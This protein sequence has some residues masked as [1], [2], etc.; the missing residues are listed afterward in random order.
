MAKRREFDVLIVKDF[1]RFARDHILVCDY[2]DQIF[3]FLGIRFLSV[4]DGYD[5]SKANGRTS[6]IDIGFRNIVNSYYSQD[7][8]RKVKS[9]MRTKATKGIA[10]SGRPPFGY[11]KNKGGYY[12]IEPIAASVVSY[13]FDLAYK[14]LTTTAIA[15][16]LNKEQIP[17]KSMIKL[18][19]IG[20]RRNQPINKRNYWTQVSIYR[21]LRD[22]QYLGKLIFGK[23]NKPSVSDKRLIAVPKEDWIV[24]ANAHD[25][26]IQQEIFDAV[27]SSF[28]KGHHGSRNAQ[29][30][31]FL[32]KIKCGICKRAM[33]RTDTKKPDYFCAT[34][35]Y[36]SET[37]CLKEKLSEDFVIQM[38]LELLKDLIQRYVEVDKIKKSRSSC[39]SPR[40]NLALYQAGLEKVSQKKMELFDLWLE[41]NIEKDEYLLTLKELKQSTIEWK[42]AIDRTTLQIQALT[43][44]DSKQLPEIDVLQKWFQSKTLT[45]EMVDLFINCIYIY[46]NNQIEIDWNFSD[47]IN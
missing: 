7:L 47:P 16:R 42:N 1:S 22:E 3:P 35:I 4:N 30:K 38:V 25:P 43:A 9:A 2:L 8:S 14:G 34:P 11:R 19:T 12:E 40:K 20:E 15:Q 5:G 41:G 45:R 36:T 37:E 33:Q 13:V 21:I 24:I 39:D 46:P 44:N 10:I 23:T 27:Q 31:L 18:E 17:T 26:I 6:S 29:S 32:G 28:R